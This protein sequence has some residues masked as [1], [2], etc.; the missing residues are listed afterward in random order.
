MRSYCYLI[1]VF[2]SPEFEQIDETKQKIEFTKCISTKW[3]TVDI[4]FPV[5]HSE[6]GWAAD[7]KSDEFSMKSSPHHACFTRGFTSSAFIVIETLIKSL[8]IIYLTVGKMK[9]ECGKVMMSVRC[10]VNLHVS[11]WGFE[12]FY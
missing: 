7:N 5:E 1:Y 10:Q 8:T 6:F 2:Y 4:M 9:F 11:V 12:Q 3:A